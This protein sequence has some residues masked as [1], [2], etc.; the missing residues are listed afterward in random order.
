ML[1]IEFCI[2]IIRNA[3]LHQA[4]QDFVNVV[5]IAK[6]SVRKNI[7]YISDKGFRQCY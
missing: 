3:E 1:N 2:M 5:E 4:A 7:G 6:L